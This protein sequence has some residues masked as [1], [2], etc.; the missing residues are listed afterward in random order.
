MSISLPLIFILA[1]I[2]WLIVRTLRLRWWAWSRW[3]CSASTSPAVPPRRS[4][5]TPLAVPG[6]EVINGTTNK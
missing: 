4:S 2:A 5:M 6:V 1:V 3:C